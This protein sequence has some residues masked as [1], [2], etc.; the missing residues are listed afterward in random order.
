MDKVKARLAE[1]R[2][3]VWAYRALGVNEREDAALDGIEMV[4]GRYADAILELVPE[5]ARFLPPLR[6]PLD[7]AGRMK[8]GGPFAGVPVAVGTMDA[9]TAM[10]GLG[11]DR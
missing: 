10:F 2:A 6:D 1:A 9:W 11:V 5:A 7:V 8:T 3:A 4:I